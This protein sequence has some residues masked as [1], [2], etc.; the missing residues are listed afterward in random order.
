MVLHI[1][2]KIRPKPFRSTKNQES[3]N[4]GFNHTWLKWKNIYKKKVWLH[5][6]PQGMSHYHFLKPPWFWKWIVILWY[7]PYFIYLFI[8]LYYHIMDSLMVHK[9]I[10]IWGMFLNIFYIKF[11]KKVTFKNK[12][13]CFRHIMFNFQIWVV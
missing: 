7:N 2:K 6:V 12:F 5:V 8:I 13:K 1:G 10:Q 11:F 9:L 3:T 4:I